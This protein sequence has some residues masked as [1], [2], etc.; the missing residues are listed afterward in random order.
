M[1]QGISITRGSLV[2]RPPHPAFVACSTKSKEKQATKA[3]HGGLGM[4]LTR[5]G[6]LV[7]TLS[8]DQDHNPAVHKLA[9]TT[10]K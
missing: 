5:D 7:L 2:P 3:G 1:E 9:A 10:A 6:P 4:R 8:C